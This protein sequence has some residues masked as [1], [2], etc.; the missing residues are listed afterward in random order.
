MKKRCVSSKKT[1]Y[2]LKER[3]KK[4]KKRESIYEDTTHVIYKFIMLITF[5]LNR[6]FSFKDIIFFYI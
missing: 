1:T 2:F 4:D 6:S 5:S 3:K